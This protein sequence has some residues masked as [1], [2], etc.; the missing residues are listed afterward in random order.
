MK[1]FRLFASCIPVKGAKRSIICDL[2]RNDFIFISEGLYE[3]LVKYKNRSINYIKEKYGERLNETIDEYFEYLIET[4]YG[5]WT[6]ESD[7]P[8][9]N[10]INLS[11]ETPELINNAIVDINEHSKHNYGKIFKELD[12]LRCKFLEIRSYS[13]VYIEN[14]LNDIL[15]HL[16]DKIFRNIRLYLKYY[17]T[18]YEELGKS[19]VLSR[20]LTISEI[21]IHSSPENKLIDNKRF[22]YLI[23][24]KSKLESHNDCGN[25][26]IENFAINIPT[27]SESQQFNSCLNK[28]ISIDSMGY[29][30]NC[31]AMKTQ[32]GNCVDTS[33]VEIS[34]SNKFQR[35]WTI[36]KSQITICKDC[37]FRF[38][39]TDCRAFVHEIY[40]KPTKCNYDPYLGQWN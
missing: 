17:P 19:N 21:I 14:L 39:C 30:K 34:K 33:M 23:F 4:E 35:V 28:K 36:D 16:D 20:N 10:E 26:C 38:I 1:I 37:E 40:D 5:F 9:F 2:Q 31:P 32:Y 29:I 3:I 25:I 12:L 6:D 11:F 13:I 22:N 24:Q 8:N 18:I 15:V 7:L 27:F